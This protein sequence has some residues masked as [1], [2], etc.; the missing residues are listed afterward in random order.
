MVL[1]E[2]GILLVVGLILGVGGALLATR[3]MRGLLFG[4][5]PNDPVT[6]VGVAVMMALV[7]LGA[8]W[9]PALRAARIHP[10]IA[11]R[12]Q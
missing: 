10:A 12:G 5:A 3:L 9:L 4:V 6:L 7:G 11:I 1:M 2:G 8:C